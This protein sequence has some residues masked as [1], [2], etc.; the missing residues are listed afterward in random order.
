MATYLY[1]Q[2]RKNLKKH[3]KGHTF[4]AK[5][6]DEGVTTRKDEEFHKWDTYKYFIEYDDYLMF[7]HIDGSMSFLPKTEELKEII[8]FTKTKIPQKI[9]KS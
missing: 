3:L 6:N 5:V 2:W 1:I 8:D 4:F 9:L 7:K